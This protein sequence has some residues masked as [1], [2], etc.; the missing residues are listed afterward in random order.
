MR[1]GTG[2]L[3]VLAC[4]LMLPA[5]VSAQ[6]SFAGQVT[7]NSGGV[8]PGVTV[9][10]ASPILIGGTRVA[11][12][13]GAGQYTIID[14]RPGTYT[15]TFELPGFGTQVRAEIVLPGDF[16]VTI[17]VALSIGGVEETITVSGASPVVDIQ[18]VARSETLTR[19]VIEAIPTGNSLWSF[20][21][22]IPGVKVLNPD[23]GGTEAMQ[24]SLMFGRGASSRQTTVE[25]DGLN[26][27]TMNDDGRFKQYNNPQMTSEITITTT[28]MNAETSAGGLRMNIIPREGGNTLSGS[29]FA[30]GTP[31]QWNW[32]NWNQHL[33][34]LNVTPVD[35]ETGLSGVPRVSKIYDVNMALGG[36][37][38]ND[39]LWF[40]GAYRD[41]S[42]DEVILNALTRDGEPAIDDNRINSMLL[43][44]TYQAN[45][46]NKIS[47][48]FDRIFKRR[49]HQ[50]GA[51]EDRLTGSATTEPNINYYQGNAKWTSTLSSRMLFETGISFV[52]Q[53]LRTGN[54]ADITVERPTAF[55]SCLS[56]PCAPSGTAADA[57][58]GLGGVA[59]PW[60]TNIRRDDGRLTYDYGSNGLETV[61]EPYNSS[62]LASLSYVT[63]SHNIKVGLVN[64]W[65]KLFNGQSGN[66]DINDINYGVGDNP[67]GHTVPWITASHNNAECDASG[68]NCA[69]IGDPSSVSI[70]NS[71]NNNQREVVY[72]LGIYAQDSW[73][74]DRLTL[75]YGVRIEYAKPANP[76][77]YKSAGRFSDAR[78]FPKLEGLPPY[79]NDVA[80]RL[81]AVYDLFGD[82]RTAAKVG[83]GRYY[84]TFGISAAYP[85]GSYTG[86]SGRSDTRDWF[87][88]TL[89]P[90]TDTPMGPADCENTAGA[91][92]NPYGTDGDNIVQDW[93]I[94]IPGN[95]LLSTIGSA[96]TP[97]AN[98]QRSYDEVLTVGLSHEVAPGVSVNMEYRRRWTKDQIRSRSISRTFEVDANGNFVDGDVWVTAGE[99]RAPLPYGGVIPIYSIF[100]GPEGDPTAIHETIGNDELLDR[101]TGFELSMNARMPGGGVLFGGWN[102]ETPGRG[103]SAGTRDSCA[104]VLAEGDNPN[105]LRFCDEFLLPRYWRNEF[106][107][108]GAQP[109][110]WDLQLAGSYQV[111]PG[112]GM[113]ERIRVDR[114]GST[115]N[116]LIYQAP[117][118]DA[119]NCFDPCVIGGRF[120]SSSAGG[121][122]QLGTSTTGIDITLLPDDTVKYRPNWTQF[123]MS[124]ARIFNI[125]G[126]RLD[127]RFEGFNIFNEGVE[128]EGNLSSRGNALFQQ[129]NRFEDATV[130]GFGRVVRISATARF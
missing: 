30:G 81:S 40:F 63:G 3:I 90:G 88:V 10:A 34:D 11:V 122:T 111:Y 96:T 13:D 7:D 124:I 54:Q 27:N 113:A 92:T 110:P 21:A 65:G 22:L 114:R 56:T 51:N 62:F 41:W 101:F 77:Q 123:D 55:Q 100:R 36:P 115:T 121:T 78:F 102:T 93:E 82:A 86:A 31:R 73:T 120:V 12:T 29:V 129:N 80:P 33:G 70:R 49:F 53:A 125:G 87:D 79:K 19:E 99:F 117:W 60:Y 128:R 4:L 16:T 39:K 103:E 68:A 89:M 104:Q 64:N 46:N 76:D 50:F 84:H 28:G 26:S 116:H 72:D 45:T 71:P 108:S 83:W 52:G 109:L 95:N 66:G 48:Y 98:L 8:L 75:N 9:G 112:V 38:I 18:R 1:L 106:K 105:G 67:W 59:D 5:G 23:V 24:Q 74:L 2:A 107:I 47:S 17:D 20:A 58:Q 126:W 61:T 37:I 94:G 35:P 44:L 15:L 42:T 97:D 14:L 69:L 91:C 43:R 130:V 118:Y 119:T 32:D 25:V 127:A 85:I 57:L 6:S